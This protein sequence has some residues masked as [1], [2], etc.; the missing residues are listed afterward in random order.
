VQSSWPLP[1]FGFAFVAGVLPAAGFL[2]ELATGMFAEVAFPLFPTPLHTFAVGL[3]VVLNLALHAPRC[4][5]GLVWRAAALGYVT[6]SA[7][8]YALAE[9][10]ALP[11]ILFAVTFCGLGLLAAAPFWTCLGLLWL[12]PETWRQWRAAGRRGAT[13]LLVAAPAALLVPGLVVASRLL[14]T[15]VLEHMHAVAASS[16]PAAVRAALDWLRAAP[17][18]PQDAICRGGYWF[19]QNRLGEGD[20]CWFVDY[21]QRP[22]TLDVEAARGVYHRVHGCAWTDPDAP[23]RLASSRLE[24]GVERDAAVARVD[25]LLEFAN[26]G[27]TDVEARAEI[28]LLEGA[29]A[30][31]LS[32]WIGGVER[33]AAF[34][35]A[36]Q[37][38]AAYEEVVRKRRDPA[39]LQETAPGRLLLQVFPVPR[40][41]GQVRVRVGCTVPLQLRDDGNWLQLPE[42]V[43]TACATA[44]VEHRVELDDGAGRR[45]LRRTF[46]ALGA[47][48]LR[49]DRSAPRARCRDAD[50]VL[51]QELVPVPAAAVPSS[52]PV[53]L[54]IDASASAAEALP[55]PSALLDALPPDTRCTVLVA[56][57]AGFERREGNAADGALRSWLA[58][59]PFQGG[60]DAVPML[61]VAAAAAAAMPGT[62]VV[63]LH[64]NQPVEHTP[65]ARLRL[66]LVG[67]PLFALAL[68]EGVNVVRD[69]VADAA[70]PLARSGDPADDVRCLFA[71]GPALESFVRR[72]SRP[73]ADAPA[74]AVV[75]DQLGR[76]WAAG[77]A[78]ALRQNGMAAAAAAFASRYRLVT[79][80]A[81]AVVLETGAQ[82]AANGLDPG[83]TLGTE[84]HGQPLGSPVPEPSTAVL[85]A[86][87]V[88][89]LLLR[90]RAARR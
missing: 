46:G 88:L 13:L 19:D 50:G 51:E 84:P 4:V 77:E 87:G 55:R 24:V 25:W 1:R 78:R 66:A 8:V 83:A 10:S 34:G 71:R 32:L 72:W 47:T 30:S 17:V 45:Q 31:A 35:P 53:V 67:V 57:S 64:G 73:G 15:R 69:E 85:L 21:V 89:L 48:P 44:G 39:L 62:R 33:P 90:A 29:V 27:F 26:T 86:A 38:R 18:G 54:A 63:W 52:A 79:A 2:A 49:F 23:L 68:A 60:V 37:A 20:L 28:R 6:G 9:S 74:A 3:A 61:E 70:L 11:L 41:G 59:Q 40:R 36:A 42:L 14:Q 81:A 16:D 12:W 82:Y 22:V 76:L 80:G 7:L 56:G 65:C 58:E 75:S 43:V 5:P